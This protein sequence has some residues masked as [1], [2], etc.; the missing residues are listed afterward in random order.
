[1][2]IVQ[3]NRPSQFTVFFSRGLAP[4]TAGGRGSV[5][6]EPP[7]TQESAPRRA[8]GRAGR[9]ARPRGWDVGGEF[10]INIRV[11]SE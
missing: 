10:C 2:S 8:A 1:M 9:R 6:C 11:Y 3:R 5:A 4:R 7:C